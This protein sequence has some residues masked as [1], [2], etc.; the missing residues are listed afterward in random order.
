MSVF[1]DGTQPRS[2]VT[3]LRMLLCYNSRAEEMLT[4][5]GLQS[6]KYL[7]FAL[8]EKV[9]QSLFYTQHSSQSAKALDYRPLI[10]IG[11]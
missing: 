2:F 10:T 6:L 7:Q 11:Y 3:Y 9:C 1:A 4:P 8:T 5:Y